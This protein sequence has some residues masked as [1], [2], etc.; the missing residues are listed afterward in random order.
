MDWFSSVADEAFASSAGLFVMETIVGD[1]EAEEPVYRIKP[2]RTTNEYKFIGQLLGL[3]Y[4]KGVPVN[5]K[6]A[7]AVS[8]LIHHHRHYPSP[9]PPS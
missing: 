2:G 4:K 7:P 8:A 1:D 9:P 5:V 3:A 6:L